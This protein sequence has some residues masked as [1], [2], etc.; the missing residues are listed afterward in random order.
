[1]RRYYCG[2]KIACPDPRTYCVWFGWLF[3]NISGCMCSFGLA[4]FVDLDIIRLLPCVAARPSRKSIWERLGGNKVRAWWWKWQI[5]WLEAVRQCQMTVS[6]PKS[7]RWRAMIDS[8][9]LEELVSKSNTIQAQEIYLCQGR[10]QAKTREN[11][12]Y[13]C[14]GF[15]LI[16]WDRSIRLGSC[17][18][19]SKIFVFCFSRSHREVWENP[20]AKDWMTSR[21][22]DWWRKIMNFIVWW[23]LRT[24]KWRFKARTTRST[25]TRRYWEITRKI[26]STQTLLPRDHMMGRM[27]N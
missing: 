17:C 10:L 3:I 23:R 11:Y 1:M 7:P 15:P 24:A 8:T 9:W 14:D 16:S 12:V 22:R 18:L 27:T 5:S 20:W 13:I 21:S 2:R 26:S 4:S 6:G 25:E 19:W